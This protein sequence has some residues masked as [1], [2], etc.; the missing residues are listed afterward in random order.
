MTHQEAREHV[1]G[2]LHEIFASP[3]DAFSNEAVERLLHIHIMLHLLV[4]RPMR[5]RHLILRVIH[6]WENGSFSPDELQY[7]DYPLHTFDDF[8]QVNETFQRAKAQQEPLP[9]NSVSLLAEPLDQAIAAAN[10]QGQVIDEETRLIPARWPT[11]P[12]G[13]SLYTMFKMYNRL[14]YG[15]DEPYRSSHCMSEEGLREIHEFHLE[16]GEFAI[17]I[18]PGPQNKTENTL[19]VMHESQ[20]EPVSTIFA[21]SIP[22]FE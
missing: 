20:L 14:V 4:V 1:P 19:M 2:R 8:Q 10:A 21:L 16:E 17:V 15:E 7:I 18:P 22:L 11:F 9:S 13:L 6:G 12:K 5:R 3:Y